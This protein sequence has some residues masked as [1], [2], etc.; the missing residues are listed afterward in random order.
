MQ[1]HQ[2]SGIDWTKIDAV[3]FDV[4][5][6][7][8][9]HTRLRG[10]MLGLLL[11]RVLTQAGGL[12]E[13]QI[14]R[15][16]RKLR[17]HLAEEEAEGIDRKQ[18]EVVANALRCSVADVKAAVERWIYQAPL[19]FVPR[20]KMPGVDRFF[21]ALRGRSLPIGVFSDYPADG[22]LK[23]LGL[24]ADLVCD[25][26]MPEIGRLKPHPWGFEYVAKQ[27]GA[28][29]QRSL[30]V[31]DRDDRDGEAAK[32]GGFVFIKKVAS[33]PVKKGEFCSYAELAEEVS[34][35]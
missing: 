2:R 14:V 32:R 10:H 9:E 6:T 21:S 29:P 15:S 18:Y 11:Q 5:G 25:A 8:F 33:Q 1:Q 20:Y 7:L 19:A 17:E 34:T 16:F 30:I 24:I 23:A 27:L 13:A 4:D 3:I 12:R 31:G 35:R 28:S 22:K 26:T